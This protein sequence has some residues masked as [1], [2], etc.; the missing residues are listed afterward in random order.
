MPQ[1]FTDAQLDRLDAINTKRIQAAV[2]NESKP[3]KRVLLDLGARS[4]HSL[5]FPLPA[6]AAEVAAEP[7]PEHYSAWITLK[8]GDVRRHAV[9]YCYDEDEALEQAGRIA[10][11]I[12]GAR[13]SGITVLQRAA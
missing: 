6:V 9:G 1:P 7:A 2:W 11:R 4:G 3:T 13:V 10:A 8:G 12:Y 5:P